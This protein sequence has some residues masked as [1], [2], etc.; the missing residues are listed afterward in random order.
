MVRNWTTRRR[1]LVRVSRWRLIWTG[2]WAWLPMRGE[3]KVGATR[4]YKN[5]YGERWWLLSVWLHWGP[6][7]VARWCDGLKDSRAACDAAARLVEEKPT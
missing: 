7:E 3:Y 5:L 4:L 6:F 1:L 2:S